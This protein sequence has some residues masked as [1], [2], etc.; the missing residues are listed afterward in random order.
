M[1]HI[2]IVFNFSKIIE[3]FAQ[4]FIYSLKGLVS[5]GKERLTFIMKKYIANSIQIFT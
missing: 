1:T 5:F 4:L 3:F 2:K